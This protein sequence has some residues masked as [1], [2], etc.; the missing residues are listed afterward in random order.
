MNVEQFQLILQNISDKIQRSDTAMREAI[1]AKDKL[2]VTLSFLATGNSFRTL[3]HIF[4]VPKPS[5]STFLPEVFDAIY[6]F[7][8]DYIKVPETNEE[9]GV[10]EN[11]FRTRWNYP[12]CY[13]A[14][15]GKHVSIKAPNQCGNVEDENK[16]EIFE[17]TWRR[18]FLM[19]SIVNTGSNHSARQ[20]RELRERY[21]HYFT[22]EG[23]VPWQD[24][25]IY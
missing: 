6:D 7:L 24:R 14:I 18:D 5:I 20:A 17:G 11:G 22:H 12:G 23:A 4:R 1:S 25:M 21:K 2:Q 15:D 8:K 13:G 9:W 3:Q 10:L 16:G 19:P